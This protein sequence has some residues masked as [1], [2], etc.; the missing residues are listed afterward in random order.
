MSTI[1][2]YMKEGACFKEGPLEAHSYRLVYEPETYKWDTNG[3]LCSK[4]IHKIHICFRIT[5]TL[6]PKTLC[7]FIEIF[8]MIEITSYA[9]IHLLKKISNMS[10][11][12]DDDNAF[13]KFEFYADEIEVKQGSVM[14]IKREKSKAIKFDEDANHGRKIRF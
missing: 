4:S 12:H 7:K 1:Q 2:F 13:M 6:S 5:G 3:N 10:I 9:G 11:V 8:D 14:P